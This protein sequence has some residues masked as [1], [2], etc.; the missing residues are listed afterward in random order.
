MRS[1]DPDL[2]LLARVGAKFGAIGLTAHRDDARRLYAD[3][4]AGRRPR[5]SGW[6]MA[7]RK[8]PS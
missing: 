8:R 7:F 2:D 1:G 5:P 4:A 6:T 3:L